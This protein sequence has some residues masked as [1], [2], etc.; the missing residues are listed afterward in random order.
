[1]AHPAQRTHTGPPKLVAVVQ[2]DPD[3]RAALAELVQGA[4]P[5]ALVRT[6]PSARVA[7]QDVRSGLRPQAICVQDHEEALALVLEAGGGEGT[8]VVVLCPDILPASR[9]W[10]GAQATLVP[11][12]PE[13]SEL[14]AA[15]Q[16]ACAGAQRGA[17]AGFL[18]AEEATS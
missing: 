8:P 10:Q 1:M 5:E 15:L 3:V 12:P 14:A 9:R 18:E 2:H 4:A 11:M 7:L 16:E 17:A 6:Y 13:P